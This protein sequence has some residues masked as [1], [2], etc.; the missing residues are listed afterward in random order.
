MRKFPEAAFA[1][2]RKELAVLKRL[3]TPQKIQDYLDKLK[4]NFETKHATLRSPLMV[5][6]RGE[7]QCVEGA[8]LAAAA[9][10]YHGK[11]PLL[12][13]LLTTEKDHGHVVAVFKQGRYWGSISKT[14]HAVLQYRDPVFKNMREIAMSYFNEYF[15]DNGEKTLRTYSN[16]FNMLQFGDEWLVARRNLWE[17]T[18]AMDRI[19]HFKILAPG[20]ERHLRLAHPLERRA[21]KL[22]QWRKKR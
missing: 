14:N 22:V 13:D 21:G 2:Y 3:D 17:V 15:L 9:F 7:A 6:R 4:I 11:P 5:I 1:N 16:P 18:D 19:P 12:L 10:W 8:M 20:A